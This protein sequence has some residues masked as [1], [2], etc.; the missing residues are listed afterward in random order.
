MNMKLGGIRI[1]RVPP[2]T[3]VPVERESAYFSLLISGIAIDPIVA[4]QATAELL[5]AANNA[6]APMEAMA[7][8][9]GSL[10]NHL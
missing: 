6:H 4:A 10:P 1:P 8:P 9:P 2:E 5:I 3:V 7:T